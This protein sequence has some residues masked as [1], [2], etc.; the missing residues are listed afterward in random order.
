MSLHVCANSSLLNQPFLFPGARPLQS[1]RMPWGGGPGDILAVVPPPTTGDIL[2][3]A[4]P[5]PGD[6]LMVVPHPRP[7]VQP[8]RG[9][10]GIS[11]WLRPSAAGPT[12]AL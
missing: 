9:Q 11:S 5:N 12:C 7:E 1:T 10:A 6:I 3:V 8:G 4:S 2:M